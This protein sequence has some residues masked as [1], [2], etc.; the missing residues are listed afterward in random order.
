MS[1]DPKFDMFLEGTP[2]SFPLEA[3]TPKLQFR[4]IKLDA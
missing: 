2:Y 1:Y 3:D 4:E